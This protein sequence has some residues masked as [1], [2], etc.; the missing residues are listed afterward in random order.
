LK[1]YPDVAEISTIATGT[2]SPNNVPPFWKTS[3]PKFTNK[4]NDQ[5]NVPHD[6]A[7]V[8]I[9]TRRFSDWNRQSI[10]GGIVQTCGMS[11]RDH[12]TSLGGHDPGR[13]PRERAFPLGGET[14]TT[15]QRKRAVTWIIVPGLDFDSI[16][17]NRNTL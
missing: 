6:D 7:N 3:V 15:L 10:R 2:P 11:G 17:L 8:G 13:R 14:L 12:G 4:R 5:T 9:K 1:N 16:R